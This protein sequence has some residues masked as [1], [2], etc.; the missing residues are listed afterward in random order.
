MIC[1]SEKAVDARLCLIRL[2]SVEPVVMSVLYTFEDKNRDKTY[3]VFRDKEGNHGLQ[4]REYKEANG[5]Y[6]LC[7]VEDTDVIYEIQALLCVLK[8]QNSNQ[9]GI[10]NEPY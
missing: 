6:R 2:G 10:K 8:Y 4:I 1:L 5:K 9:G 7:R 3:L